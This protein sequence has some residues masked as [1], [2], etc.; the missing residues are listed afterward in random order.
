MKKLLLLVPLIVFIIGCGGEEE[1]NYFPLTVGNEWNYG[2][3][4]TRT[5]PDTTL[6]ETGS[7]KMEITDE[8]TLDNDTDVFEQVMTITFTD[9]L[10]PDV[11]DTSYFQETDDYIFE[12]DDKTSTAPDDTVLAL[13]LEE[14]KTWGN[15][16]VTGQ[17][18]V[19]VDAG[20]FDDC[21]EIMVIENGDTTYLYLAPNVGMVKMSSTEVEAEATYE[22]LMELETY[23]VQ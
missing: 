12:Y 5:D 11:V 1:A 4:M 7:A 14:G 10:I 21:W 9:T 17:E 20:S 19:T 15:Y 2:F 6:T 3:E 8:T 23:T 22:M 13:P 18:D 16:E